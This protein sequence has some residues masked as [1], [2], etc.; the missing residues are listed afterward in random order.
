M[1]GSS[2]NSALNKHPILTNSATGFVLACLGDIVTQKYL[3]DEEKKKRVKTILSSSSSKGLVLHHQNNKGTTTKK[4]D[5][6][7]WQPGR[8]L[9]MGVIRAAVG[10]YWNAI[11]ES[12]ISL[13]TIFSPSPPV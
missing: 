12:L 9:E 5:T 10:Q 1:S 8:T 4:D 6:S 13:I 7:W 2:Y 11:I 3:A